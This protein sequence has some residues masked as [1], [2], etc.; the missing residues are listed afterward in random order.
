ME[1]AALR[2]HVSF[3][4][5]R[6]CLPYWLGPLCAI[7][8]REQLQQTTGRECAV[9]RLPRRRGRAVA[10]APR[11]SAT[12]HRALLH[13][14]I[15]VGTGS[16]AHAGCATSTFAAGEQPTTQQATEVT[17]ERRI[18][19]A[20]KDLEIF[21]ARAYKP[22]NLQAT[23]VTLERIIENAIKDLD[24]ATA[25]TLNADQDRLNELMRKSGV[26]DTGDM[27]RRA[28]PYI[29]RILRGEKPAAL[30][31][32]LPTKFQMAVNLK[33][34]KA[35]GLTL[36]HSPMPGCRGRLAALGDVPKQRQGGAETVWP[37]A[38]PRGSGQRKKG[39]PRKC[40]APVMAASSN[41]IAVSNANASRTMRAF[42]HVPDLD[43][44]SIQINPPRR[45][46]FG[47]PNRRARGGGQ[48][49]PRAQC[50]WSR[51]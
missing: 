32:Q 12:D 49:R 34:A 11:C 50:Y 27:F 43:Y 44:L 23:E 22:D 8:G 31:V 39:Q 18:E 9:I 42:I 14:V 40:R 2:Q 17:L 5:L 10:L 16:A 28:A 3:R 7:T 29:D 30:P 13:P 24:S 46:R 48:H 1:F 38:L 15:C 21:N 35:L 26:Y 37:S 33:T 4:R 47:P 41:S 36:P 51:S 6:T 25:R 20:L 19:N 45:R